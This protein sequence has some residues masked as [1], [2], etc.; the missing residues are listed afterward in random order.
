MSTK[1]I[2]VNTIFVLT[3][4]GRERSLPIEDV[5]LAAADLLQFI[6][7]RS[8]YYFGR[9]RIKTKNFHCYCEIYL[10]FEEVVAALDAPAASLF[11]DILVFRDV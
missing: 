10:H 6:W 3:P 11:F 1:E 9:N 7:L 5:R 2:Y 4:G 8:A